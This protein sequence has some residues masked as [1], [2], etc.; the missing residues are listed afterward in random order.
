MVSDISTLDGIYDGYAAMIM[1]SAERQES[2]TTYT[3]D[4]QAGLCLYKP[5]TAISCVLFQV[6]D[7]STRPATTS[8]ISLY[9]D[10]TNE[11]SF[12]PEGLIYTDIGVVSLK[13]DGSS[14]VV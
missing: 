9:K 2:G 11:T 8:K 4:D 13:E 10:L 5:N 12:D 1:V 3:V 14:N 7:V 6:T